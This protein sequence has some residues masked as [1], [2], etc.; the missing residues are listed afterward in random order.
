MP[1]IEIV[2]IKRKKRLKVPKDK[3]HFW[4]RQNFNLK[5]HRNLFQLHLNKYQGIILHLGNLDMKNSSPWFFGNELIDWEYEMEED[6][7]KFKSKH[8]IGVQSLISRALLGS[9]EGKVFFLTDIQGSEKGEIVTN[10][11]L[12]QFIKEH[13]I[14]GLEWNTLYEIEI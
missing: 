3:Y 11:S 2:S 6:R 7:F 10:Y 14:S 13:E 4:V 8:F 1:T 12:N 9:P 5:S